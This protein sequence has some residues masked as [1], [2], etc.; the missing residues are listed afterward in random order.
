MADGNHTTTEN[1]L[2]EAVLTILADKP[3]GRCRYSELYD[4]IPKVVNLTASD[5]EQSPTRPNEQ[6]WQQRLR[7]IRSHHG[8]EGNYITEGYLVAFDGGLE[9]TDAGRRRAARR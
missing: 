5:R 6:M 2:A 9:I 3:N 1:E 4:T 7:N 8:A